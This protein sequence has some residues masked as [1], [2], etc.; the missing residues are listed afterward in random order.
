MNAPTP[1]AGAQGAAPART[2]PAA[3]WM[4]GVRAGAVRP[5]VNQDVT[6]TDLD[7]EMLLYDAADGATHALN[8][9]AALVWELCDGAHTLD[10]IAAELASGF[11]LP[12]EQAHADAAALVEQ[13][14]SLGLLNTAAESADSSAG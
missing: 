12:A 5:L 2:A 11:N 10:D 14:F 13:F 9:T 6:V 8:F 1:D 7:D 4:D 3:D